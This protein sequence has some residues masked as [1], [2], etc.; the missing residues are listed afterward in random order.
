MNL[1]IVNAFLKRWS[2]VRIRPGTLL[3]RQIASLGRSPVS[4]PQHPQKRVSGTNPVH[5]SFLREVDPLAA[6]RRVT[7]GASS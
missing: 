4:A 2:P 6:P 7:V 5:G 1:E 3:D